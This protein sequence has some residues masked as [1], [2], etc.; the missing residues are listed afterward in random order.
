MNPSLIALAAGLLVAAS[1]MDAL[2]QDGGEK[3]KGEKKA[4][5]A[6]SLLEKADTDKDGKLSKEEY[7]HDLYDKFQKQQARAASGGGNGKGKGNR[8]G[9][10]DKNGD[11]EVS[12][13]EFAASPMAAERFK[14]A[15]KDGSGFLEKAELEGMAAEAGRA[16]RASLPEFVKRFDEN[17]DGKVSREEFK[18]AP[19]IFDRMD[20]NKDG[21]V[22]PGDEAPAG[23]PEPPAA[24][25]DP[26][27]EPKEPAAPTPPAAP[28]TPGAP[29]K[30][31]RE[32]GEF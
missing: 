12:Y 15:D 23:N 5:S 6:E 14:A 9:R 28:S 19:A 8:A 17:G 11:G 7:T 29:E 20:R 18:G 4:P 22:G 27:A 2:A 30:G 16:Q 32:P 3:K 24:P 26:P 21:F 25:K 31:D 10:L 1:A 13:E